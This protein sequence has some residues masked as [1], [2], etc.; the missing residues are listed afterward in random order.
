MAKKTVAAKTAKKAPAPKPAK[1]AKP[2]AEKKSSVKFISLAVR[3]VIPTQQYGNV[4]PEIVVQAATYEEARDFVIPRIEELYQ[5]YAEEPLN[6]RTPKIM[7]PITETVREVAPAAEKAPEAAPAPVAAPTPAP[8][9]PEAQE[10]QMPAGEKP[11]AVVKA[12]KAINAASAPD[13]ALAVQEQI[14]KSV[15]IPED[16]K[17]YLINLVLTKRNA[18]K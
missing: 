14:E 5:K 8:E 15:K 9:A 11:A 12:E 13:A 4:Q 6:G 10:A 16:W 1:V 3:A 18:L 17:P 7:G 2:K